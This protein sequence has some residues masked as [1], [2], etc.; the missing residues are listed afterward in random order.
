MTQ[1]PAKWSLDD[2]HRM[3]D[4]GLFDDRSVELIN[5]EIIQMTPEGVAHS[6]YCRG[7]AKYLQ[8]ILIEISRLFR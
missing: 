3:I 7:T 2:Y 5:G 6:F 4:T 1:I 8:A